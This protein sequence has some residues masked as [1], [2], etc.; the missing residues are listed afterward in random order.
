[1]A[2]LI[3]LG[4]TICALVLLGAGCAEPEPTATDAGQALKLHITEL[5]KEV[6]ALNVQITDPGG[7]DLPCGEGRAK[8]SFAA[9]GA[10][11]VPHMTADGLN[12]VL[13]A[14]LSRVAPYRI[15]EDR[16]NAP[17]RLASEEF[18]TALVLESTGD[19]QYKVRGETECLPAR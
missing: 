8:Q 6:H 14:V 1:M 13:V 12:T 15:V 11:S 4:V 18:R 5:M 9:T 7:R 2:F 3:R 19:G 17:I 10:D 16:G